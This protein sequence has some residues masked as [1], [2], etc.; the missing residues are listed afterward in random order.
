MIKQLSRIRTVNI[1]Y[2]R[3]FQQVTDIYLILEIM[4]RHRQVDTNV[5]KMW[6]SC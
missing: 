2:F 3:F 1:K 4:K 5:M 6:L